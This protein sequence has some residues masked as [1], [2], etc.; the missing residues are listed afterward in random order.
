MTFG[1]TKSTISSFLLICVVGTVAEA[2]KKPHVVLILA[3]DLGY[4]DVGYWGQNHG[5][6]AKTPFL[7]SLAENGVRLENY[8]THSVCSP[9]RGALMTG[10]NRIDIGLAH[11]IIHTTQIEGLPLDNVLLPEQ[12]SNCGY[13]T[14][15]IGKWHL[16]F[17]SSKYAPWN[18]G[19][20]GFYGFLAG[21]EN[22]WS[23]WLP[24]ARHSNIGGVD[25]TDSTTGP[26][27]ETWG[28]YSAHVYASRARY[29]IQHHDQS[30]PLFLYLPLQTPHTPLGAPSHYY[31]PFKDIEDDD[32][33]KYLSMVSVLDETVR[34][35][36]NYLKDAGMW[37]DTL[38]I[39]STDNGGEV[40]HGGNNW[41]YRG[42]K[43]TLYEGGVKAVGF[44]HGK[45]LGD[46]SP[47]Q[48]VNRELIHVTDWYPT[49]M[50]A[51]DCPYVSGNSRN[52]LYGLNQWGALRGE[53][54]SQRT[55][56]VHTIDPMNRTSEIPDM[57]FGF[58]INVK[59]A[60]CV[61]KWKLITGNPGHGGWYAPPESKDIFTKSGTRGSKNIQLFDL[62]VDPLEENEISNEHP[63]VVSE[64]LERLAKYSLSAPPAIN[65][66]TDD[67]AHLSWTDGFVQP[68]LN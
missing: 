55:E 46:L 2:T 45:I 61:R 16:G 19:F 23:K 48:R 17:S 12:L 50:A 44:V 33:M 27:N 13:N 64:L 43:N 51:A 30:K 28:Q 65:Q 26:T 3:D 54:G 37:E 57:R 18:R 59:A 14:Q 68:W 42:T 21:S 4:N 58:N 36:T 10:R 40:K 34:N 29:V 5:S 9:T 15:M 62:S 56:I 7:D 53:R 25:F 11:G 67:N 20:H 52:K 41:P 22:Y 1:T 49:I 39:F 60:I 31:E 35:V 8:Y 47:A 32:R 6:A 63:T 24:M 66:N 38:L